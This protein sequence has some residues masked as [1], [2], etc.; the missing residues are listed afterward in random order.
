M[1]GHFCILRPVSIVSGIAIIL[2]AYWST[3][4]RLVLVSVYHLVAT[5]YIYLP[6]H[7]DSVQINMP[8]EICIAVVMYSVFF[9]PFCEKWLC[10]DNSAIWHS[11]FEWYKIQIPI[12]NSLH[13]CPACKGCTIFFWPLR[14]VCGYDALYLIPYMPM[15]S[16]DLGYWFNV[17][18]YTG[19]HGPMHQF[20]QSSQI[21]LHSQQSH[22]VQTRWAERVYQNNELSWWLL[23]THDLMGC[24][25][26]TQDVEISV[27]KPLNVSFYHRQKYD[28]THC[29]L[30]VQLC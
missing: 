16:K 20:S 2:R 9:I 7:T 4:I 5:Q 28:V 15:T 1:L 21:K 12:S 22:S 18:L 13:K 6:A 14:M 25:A 10:C 8:I 26:P 23:W 24:K 19:A 30:C 27:N 17:I 29:L 11:S 3:V